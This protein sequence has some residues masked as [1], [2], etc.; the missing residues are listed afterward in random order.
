MEFKLAGVN[1]HTFMTNLERWVLFEGGITGF[2]A[3]F[4]L[5]Q[6]YLPLQ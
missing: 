1:N 5:Q 3:N 2:S 4:S 6:W